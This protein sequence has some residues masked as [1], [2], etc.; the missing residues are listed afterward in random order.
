ML[1]LTVI[2]VAM[3]PTYKAITELLPTTQLIIIGQL[4]EILIL[5]LEKLELF[6][7]AQV[8]QMFTMLRQVQLTYQHLRH[9]RVIH[10]QLHPT[11]RLHQN[12]QLRFIQLQFTR[13]RSILHQQYIRPQLLYTNQ[14]KSKPLNNRGLFFFIFVVKHVIV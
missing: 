7:E 5:T 8:I 4:L 3:E 13:L 10:Y 1:R 9:I 11:L 14:T 12:I 2:T 6:Q